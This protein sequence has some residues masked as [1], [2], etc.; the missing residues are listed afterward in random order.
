MINW[1]LIKLLAIGF[2]AIL[3][4]A[5][6]K[7]DCVEK[8]TIK[9]K[10]PVYKSV[11]EV[12]N[13]TA[14]A[15]NQPLQDP[16]KLYFRTDG[17]LFVGERGKGIHI[18]DNR[19]PQNPSKIGFVRIP[20]NT[21]MAVTDESEVMYANSFIDLYAIDISSPSNPEI[22]RRID[23]V[24]DQSSMPGDG[25]GK[26]VEDKGVIVDFET[27]KVTQTADC[28]ENPRRPGWNEGDFVTT[29]SGSRANVNP[30]V[31]AIGGSMARF[32]IQNNHLYSVDWSELKIFSIYNPRKPERANE[33]Q[34]SR[35]IETIFPYDDDDK[36]FIGSE[37][38]MFI[39]DNANPTDPNRLSR[40]THATACDPVYPTD[41]YA[42]VTLNGNGDCGRAESALHVVDIRD[43]SNPQLIEEY[44][45]D[46][47]KG[48]AVKD[49][50][51]FL[52]D[53]K[54]GLKVYSARNK[55]RIADNQLD[56]KSGIHAYDVIP[57][58]KTLMVVGKSGLY[59]Y[60]FRDPAN[61]NRLSWI[62]VV[63][64]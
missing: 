11:E 46:D 44:E 7:D 31:S 34:L 50:T 40:F 4:G 14:I 51:V 42:Y 64:N 39:Y 48:L 37:T 19:N 49:Q 62:P 35:G 33:K 25:I 52:C 1:K 5:C 27:E 17:Y 2:L 10:I 20:G 24:F 8:V 43:L 59:Q 30:Q 45:M 36:L 22:I 47:P 41:S 55:N 29:E 3:L 18:I 56:T 58:G 60:S 63:E 16:G 54:A 9:K 15:D 28:S 26:L 32:A 6:A 21:D 57:F 23:N 53:G 38:G 13:G 12:R 61:L